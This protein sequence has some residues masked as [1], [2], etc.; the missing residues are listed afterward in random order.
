MRSA[1]SNCRL[2]PHALEVVTASPDWE[3]AHRPHKALLCLLGNLR[4]AVL[5]RAS[6]PGGLRQA[7]VG[8]RAG[9]TPGQRLLVVLFIL[10][11]VVA[12]IA[13]VQFPVSIRAAASGRGLCTPWQQRRQPA[14]KAAAAGAQDAVQGGGG[15]TGS[16]L[17]GALCAHPRRLQ[18]PPAPVAAHERRWAGLEAPPARRA[19]PQGHCPPPPSVPTVALATATYRGSK[20]WKCRSTLLGQALDC[21]GW[22]RACGAGNEYELRRRVD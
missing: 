7:L 11:G 2:S 20:P 5:P 10:A 21:E 19:R 16:A 18:Y 1:A 6:R 8:S 17:P 4:K 3:A 12:V 14:C 9:G 15:G 13:A 22:L